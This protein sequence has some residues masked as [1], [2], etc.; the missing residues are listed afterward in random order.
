MHKRNPD[1]FSIGGYDGMHVIYESLKKTGGKTDG[2]SLIAAA[3]GLKWDSPRGP[4]SIDPETRDVVQ[5]IYIRKVEKVGGEPQNVRVRQ[6]R[7]R[8][9]SG[10]GADA[11]VRLPHNPSLPGRRDRLW[12]MPA[13]VPIVSAARCAAIAV[14][15]SGGINSR[16]TNATIEA[17]GGTTMQRAM[18]GL[19]IAAAALLAATSGRSCPGHRQDRRDHVLFRTVRRSGRRRSTTASSST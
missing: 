8:Q 17:S 13:P 5:T 16:K 18:T 1:F 4:M 2:D 12:R 19:A 15:G 7:E 9:G 10:E 11:Q 14:R 3:K 6:G